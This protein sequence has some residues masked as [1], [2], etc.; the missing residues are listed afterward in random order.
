MPP[1][2]PWALPIA[3]AQEAPAEA[4]LSPEFS[5]GFRAEKPLAAF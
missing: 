2:L 4:G 5:W 1:C 3:A